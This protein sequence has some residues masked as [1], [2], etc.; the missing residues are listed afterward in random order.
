[1]KA[2][3]SILTEIENNTT[4]DWDKI[5]PKQKIDFKIDL[6]FETESNLDV[7]MWNWKDRY[8]NVLG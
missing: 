3:D 8:L 4:I 6:T 5:K 7:M 2:E 1:M